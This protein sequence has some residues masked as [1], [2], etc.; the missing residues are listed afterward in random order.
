MPVDFSSWT[1]PP[2]LPWVIRF[3]SPPSSFGWILFFSALLGL[4]LST[5]ATAAQNCPLQLTTVPVCPR[6]L[7]HFTISSS[8][9]WPHLIRKIPSWQA[10]SSMPEGVFPFSLSSLFRFRTHSSEL[11]EATSWSPQ[12]RP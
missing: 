1:R 7:P 12:G 9:R 8:G 11:L 3:L 10:R 6:R 4:D 2:P 5:T